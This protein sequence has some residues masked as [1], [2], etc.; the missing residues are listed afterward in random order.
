MRTIVTLLACIAIPTAAANAQYLN[1]CIVEGQRVLVTGDCPKTMKEFWSVPAQGTTA[2]RSMPVQ[3]V[4]PDP[5]AE[6]ARQYDERMAQRDREQEA[7]RIAISQ[8]AAA[9]QNEC[10]RLRNERNNIQRQTI[11][12]QQTEYWRGEMNRIRARMNQL[13]C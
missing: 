12:I 3:Q 7:E 1:K 4:R 9:T 13:H 2:A 8:Q 11:P 10:N 6:L 5:N